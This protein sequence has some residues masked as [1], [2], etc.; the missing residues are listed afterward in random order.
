[1]KLCDFPLLSGELAQFT[2][3]DLGADWQIG[4]AV[5][6]QA[7]GNDYL[8]RQ[9]DS[10]CVGKVEG[11]QDRTALQVQ[12]GLTLWVLRNRHG[13]VLHLQSL[14]LVEQIQLDM[15]ISVDEAIAEQLASRGEISAPDVP[16]A[17][18]WLNEQFISAEK[19]PNSEMDRVFLGRFD[20]A[21]DESFV[22]FGAGW[23][24]NVKRD[25][26]VLKL[27]SV[28]RLKGATARVA[29][30]V[31]KI[32]FQDA[33]V[34]VRL[35]STEQRAL[36]DAALRDNGSYLRLWQE[37]GALEWEQARDCARELGSL[38]F[39]SAELV[40]GELWAWFLKVD[41]DHLRISGNDGKLWGWRTRRKWSLGIGSLILIPRLKTRRA[42]LTEH[43]V[44]RFV[45]YCGSS[46]MAWSW[47]RA[48]TGAQNA[49]QPRGSST[50]HYRVMKPYRP[51]V[52]AQGNPSMKD[53]D[54]RN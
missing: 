31:G 7:H 35:Q 43:A 11:R 14:D 26:G 13:E 45:V 16:T 25:A 42:K 9:G 4:E 52:R 17:V 30:A 36:L 21:S 54:C 51:V 1:M 22:L 12:R 3:D 27:M 50:T 40:E 6:V 8:L 44:A 32:S 37:Y 5:S 47:F 53:G 24:G 2:C 48:R 15:A 33:S 28:T 34:A 19:A 23:R 49:P 10:V 18:G 41:A 38:R 20:N 29:M 39:K 46:E